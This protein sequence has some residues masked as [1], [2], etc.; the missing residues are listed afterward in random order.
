MITANDLLILTGSAIAFLIVLAALFRGGRR[1][2]ERLFGS[3]D[4]DQL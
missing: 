3:D 1:L 4:E 2:L